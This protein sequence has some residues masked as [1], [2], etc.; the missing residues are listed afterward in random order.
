M[1]ETCFSVFH[2][3][4]APAASTGHPGVNLSQSFHVLA[5]Y[6]A[7]GSGTWRHHEVLGISGAGL[8]TKW[9]FRR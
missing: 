9:R 1:W 6:L 8:F 4:M 2:I 5:A 3:F 7:F